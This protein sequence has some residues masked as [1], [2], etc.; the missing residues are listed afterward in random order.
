MADG[1]GFGNSALR[2]L[3]GPLGDT[4]GPAGDVGD[5]FEGLG[6]IVGGIGGKL[7]LGQEAIGKLSGAVAGVGV[8]VA[9]GVVAWNLYKASQEKAKKA[10]ED[11]LSAQEAL[12]TGNAKKAA[13]DVAEAY[14]GTIVALNDAGFATADFVRTLNGSP[15]AI[16][17]LKARMAELDAQ[18]LAG[19]G[20]FE[21]LDAAF[22]ERTGLQKL[23]PE[24]EAAQQGWAT[25]TLNMAQTDAAARELEAAFGG[26]VTE[27]SNAVT[28][29]DEVTQAFGDLQTALDDQSAIESV[30]DAFDDVEDAALDAWNSAKEGAP[31]AGRRMRDYEQ[32]VRD[33]IAAVLG[34]TDE[35]EGIPNETVAAI[36]VKVQEGDLEG[37]RAL[38]EGVAKDLPPVRIGI[39]TDYLDQQFQTWLRKY[40]PG[41][42]SLSPT[43]APGAGSGGRGTPNPRLS[44]VN[45]FPPRIDPT[46]QARAQ[47]SYARV[48][49]G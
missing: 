19:K 49:G 5:A 26:V 22:A 10:A 7:G 29:I 18:L 40:G 16:N 38:L 32:K 47:A 31:D 30:R 44:I 42:S 35:L 27:A 25:N 17:A 33:A 21:Q 48:N 24:L 43:P 4:V 14:R 36:A 20:S 3:T 2:D 8:V 23:I 39:D 9:A 37:A 12:A 1:V 45:Y 41:S 34:L 6:D 28:S 46:S 13:R 11:L 15:T